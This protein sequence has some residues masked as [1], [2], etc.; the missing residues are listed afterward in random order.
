MGLKDFENALQLLE[1]SKVIRYV[2]HQDKYIL[3][4]GTDV[5][6]ELA[7]DQAGNLIEQVKDIAKHL[8]EVFELP[9]I[10]AKK[11]HYETGSPRYFEYKITQEPINEI[12]Q[13]EID[14]FINLVFSTRLTSQ[15]LKLSLSQLQGGN[16]FC[17]F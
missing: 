5:D 6:I 16:T 7:I 17:L 9:F 15:N 8:D 11:Y 12:P 10:S 4:E 2:K 14:G 3:F 13:G 1:T